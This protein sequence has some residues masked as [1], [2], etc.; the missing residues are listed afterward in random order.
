MILLVLL[1]LAAV[2]VYAGSCWWYPFAHCRWCGG[3]RRYRSD[4]KVFADCWACKGAGRRLRTG[5]RV[6]NWIQARRGAGRG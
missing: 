2:V 5:R 3:G 4:R 1:G 6:W